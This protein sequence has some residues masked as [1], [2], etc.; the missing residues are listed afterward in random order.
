MFVVV[1]YDGDMP[2]GAICRLAERIS[3]TEFQAQIHS[4]PD[5]ESA[6]FYVHEKSPHPAGKLVVMPVEEFILEKE[7]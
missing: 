2:V 5:R 7:Y 1:A 3:A 6:D 4:F